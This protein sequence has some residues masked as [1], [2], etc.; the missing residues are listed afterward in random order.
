VWKV[1]LIIK[2]THVAKGQ[3]MLAISAEDAEKI[4]K[5]NKE[6]QVLE[7]GKVIIVL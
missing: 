6:T 1:P 5:I 2:A 3:S 4:E 7:K